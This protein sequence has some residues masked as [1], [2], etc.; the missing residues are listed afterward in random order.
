[1]LCTTG[2]AETHVFFPKV[3]GFL[4]A[5]QDFSASV[6]LTFWADPFVSWGLFRAL[7]HYRMFSSIP[8]LTHW[9]LVAR[10][11]YL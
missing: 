5:S 3:L 6:R 7:A 1:M 2:S 8:G 11:L 9:I 4:L 10:L